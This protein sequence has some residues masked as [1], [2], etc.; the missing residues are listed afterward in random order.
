MQSQKVGEAGVRPA[1]EQNPLERGRGVWQAH[2]N[3][4]NCV[5]KRPWTS[6][7]RFNVTHTQAKGSSKP[8]TNEPERFNPELG[9]HGKASQPRSRMGQVERG[10]RGAD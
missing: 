2:G 10:F 5:S 6:Q 4:V 1:E 8:A 7:G 9:Q 3:S